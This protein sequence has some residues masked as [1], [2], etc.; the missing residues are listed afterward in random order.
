MY[1][2]IVDTDPRGGVG[3]GGVGGYSGLKVKGMW[4]GFVWEFKGSIPGFFRARTF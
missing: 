2:L 4:E 3:G 1:I